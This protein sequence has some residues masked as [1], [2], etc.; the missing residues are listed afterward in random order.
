MSSAPR[1]RS[2][3]ALVALVAAAAY[4]PT[5]ARSVLGGDNGEFATLFHAPGVAHPPG[6]PLYLLYLRALSGLPAASPAHG[7]ALAT[8]LL[9]AAAAAALFSAGRAWGAS[10]GASA[11]AALA[12]ALSSLPWRLATQAEVFALNALLAALF[13]FIV[14]IPLLAQLGEG[15]RRRHAEGADVS[16]IEKVEFRYIHF[17]PTLITASVKQRP[18]LVESESKFGCTKVKFFLTNLKL[19]I[20]SLVKQQWL[21]ARHLVTQTRREKLLLQ[22]DQN[23]QKS[24]MSRWCL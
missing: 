6:Y 21:L 11:F 15:K 18:L 23:W 19:M 14:A 12:W 20:A 13:A 9:G 16:G 17:V 24:M 7:A 5:A 1:D 22:P 3:A 10:R 2:T 8:A 4:L